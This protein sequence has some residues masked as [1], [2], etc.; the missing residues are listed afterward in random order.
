MKP[1]FSRVVVQPLTVM[2]NRKRE[3]Y[4][5]T[6]SRSLPLLQLLVSAG[7]RHFLRDAQ[8]QERKQRAVQLWPE[9]PPSLF[10]LLPSL[11]PANP[12]ETL[13]LRWTHSISCPSRARESPEIEN[14]WIGNITAKKKTLG[15]DRAEIKR[16]LKQKLPRGPLPLTPKD[17]WLL[18]RQ[19]D[20][21]QMKT[22]NGHPS[23]VLMMSPLPR[24]GYGTGAVS[25][26][27]TAGHPRLG[28]H[29]DSNS[30]GDE[31]CSVLWSQLGSSRA[32]ECCTRPTIST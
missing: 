4:S 8:E 26:P 29:S 3:V 1:W 6:L 23:E 21:Q 15:G 12:P 18:K 30:G 32:V 5:S 11:L 31:E 9:V 7:T 14:E 17:T 28:P 25:R 27:G 19:R 24:P 10:L 2:K 16:S 13:C 20:R 22:F